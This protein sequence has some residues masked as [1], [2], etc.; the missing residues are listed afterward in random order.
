MTLDHE[1]TS[2]LVKSE[3][4]RV[5]KE[6]FSGEKFRLKSGGEPEPLNRQVQFRIGCIG[7]RRGRSF[8]AER[9]KTND[10]DEQDNQMH[11]WKN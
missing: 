1:R 9:R 6:G 11:G 2:L 10:Q 8:R 7:F 4:D 3:A 5:L